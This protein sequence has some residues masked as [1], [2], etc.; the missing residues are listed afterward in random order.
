MSAVVT[1]LRIQYMHSGAVQWLKA[2]GGSWNNAEC[3]CGRNSNASVICSKMS[4]HKTIYGRVICV[5]WMEYMA[6][7]ECK[8]VWDGDNAYGNDLY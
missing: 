4:L 7:S 6:Q 8:E 5:H 1:T 2:F 3:S